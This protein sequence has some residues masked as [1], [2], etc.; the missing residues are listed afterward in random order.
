MNK[1]CDNC[2]YF[3]ERKCQYK[4]SE[5]FKLIIPEPKNIKCNCHRYWWLEGYCESGE[6]YHG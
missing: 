4:N 6:N 2:L 3:S 5:L 1:C